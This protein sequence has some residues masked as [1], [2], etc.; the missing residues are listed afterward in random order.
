L[1]FHQFGLLDHIKQKRAPEPKMCKI[2]EKKKK[3]EKLLLAQ[4]KD[5]FTL[6]AVGLTLS[7]IVFIFSLARGRIRNLKHFPMI[8]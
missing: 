3:L 7:S 8:T 6:L 5:C 1:L 2:T 4:L